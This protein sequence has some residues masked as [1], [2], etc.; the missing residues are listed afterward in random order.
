M[1]ILHTIITLESGGA[2]RQLS[3]IVNDDNEN[4]HMILTLADRPVFYDIDKKVKIININKEVTIAS[5]F[6]VIFKLLKVIRREKP[7]IV[8][9]WMNTNFYAPILKRFYKK[10]TYVL[11][12]R[13]GVNRKYTLL[14]KIGLKNYFRELDYTIFVSEAALKAY[15]K[16]G[17]NFPQKLVIPNGFEKVR[18]SFDLKENQDLTFIHI[19][20]YNKIKNQQ[21][22]IEAFNQFSVD[23][24][25]VKLILVGRG[26]VHSNFETYIDK[27]N[28]NKFHF[29]G[30][31]K[32]VADY[33]KESHVFIL[34]SLNEGFP[35]VIGEAMSHGLPVI[36]TDAGESYKIVGE[37]GFKIGNSTQDLVQTLNE[38]YEDRGLIHS[39][40]KQAYEW[41]NSE[42]NVEKILSTYLKFYKYGKEGL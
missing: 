33:Y 19:G 23:K 8:H 28:L 42:Y 14:K 4:Q 2:E 20:R 15:D 11:S 29:L 40:S 24:E 13:H 7:D 27:Q 6:F 1:K 39:K 32:N 18:N 22:L 38:I 37:T 9:T 30:E 41:I 21:M 16:L 26:M 3:K 12:I 17:I 35:N 10:A 36:T 34:T 31:Q 5:K 25:D